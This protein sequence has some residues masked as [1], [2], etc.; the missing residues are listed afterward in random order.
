MDVTVA[1]PVGLSIGRFH[2]RHPYGNAQPPG[3]ESRCASK[4]QFG[5]EF[6]R[7]THG[8][9]LA[10]AVVSFDATACTP[11]PAGSGRAPE[12]ALPLV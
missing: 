5:K 12:L 1:D 10:G 6:A 2:E 8:L 4:P 11:A 3:A 9:H 7:L